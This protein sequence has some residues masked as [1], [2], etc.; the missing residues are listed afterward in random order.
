MQKLFI[1]GG[2][3]FQLPAVV[4][5]KEMGLKVAIADFNPNAVAISYADKYYNVS[6]IDEEG[7]YQ[8]AKDFKADGIITLCTDMPMRALA[9]TCEKLHLNGPSLKTAIMATDKGEMIKSFEKNGVSH[10]KY[11]ILNK[12]EKYDLKKIKFPLII[13]P[14]DNSGSRGIVLVNKKEEF[15]NSLEYSRQY[16]RNGNVIIE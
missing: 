6:T 2:S 4:I 16:S 10:P 9:Y 1:I 8:A 7:I 3:D 13:K 15:E 11:F 5:A 12:N 14:I